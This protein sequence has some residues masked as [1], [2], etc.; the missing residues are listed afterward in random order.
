MRHTRL[1]HASHF[2]WK[3]LFVQSTFRHTSFALK[4]QRI[5][6]FLMSDINI[7]SQVQ[8]VSID[9]TDV[10]AKNLEHC[11]KSKRLKKKSKNS[12]LYSFSG[13]ALT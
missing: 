12:W 3:L 7:L 9:L 11:V 8:T 5:D 2:Q 13:R 4:T 10:A 6:L 1:L